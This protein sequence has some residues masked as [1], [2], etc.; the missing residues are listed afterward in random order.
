M[1]TA[2]PSTAQCQKPPC[3]MA[4]FPAR[5]LFS[6]RLQWPSRRAEQV[7]SRPFQ[8]ELAR[9]PGALSEAVVTLGEGPGRVLSSCR[10]EL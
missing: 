1:C 9:L 3:V 2:A 6:S 5:M 4:E 8:A 10:R 7:T